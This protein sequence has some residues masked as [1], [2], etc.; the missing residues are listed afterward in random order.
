MTTSFK[1][2]RPLIILFLAG[3]LLTLG[4]CKKEVAIRSFPRTLTGKVT[5]ISKNGIRF[6]GDI[7]ALGSEPVLDHGFV[8]DK[9]GKPSL[10]FGEVISLGP[11]DQRPA[12]W[13]STIR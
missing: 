8:I 12:L 13:E 5:D 6:H 10:R 4:T 9:S 3:L 7:L 11:A 1:Y 2:L